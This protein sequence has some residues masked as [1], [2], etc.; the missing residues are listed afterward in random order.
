MA[1]PPDGETN[2]DFME[3]EGLFMACFDDILNLLDLCDEEAG[4]NNQGFIESII[5]PFR[6]SRKICG[7]RFTIGKRM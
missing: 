5:K 4:D 6:I 1:T 2:V 7:S 3:N